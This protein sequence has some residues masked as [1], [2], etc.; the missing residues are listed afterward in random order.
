MAETQARGV[1]VG[2]DTEACREGPSLRSSRG[3][4]SVALPS[5]V[6]VSGARGF[7]GPPYG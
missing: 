2:A 5:F 7:P 6:P 3:D 1:R 4:A